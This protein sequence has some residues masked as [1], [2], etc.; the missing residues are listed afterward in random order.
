[1]LGA[2]SSWDKS[3]PHGRRAA[4][5]IRRQQL[6]SA[7]SIAAGGKVPGSS[8][9]AGRRNPTGQHLHRGRHWERARGTHGAYR[10]GPVHLPGLGS[11][12]RVRSSE[13]SHKPREPPPRK[14][15]QEA[16]RIA[17]QFMGP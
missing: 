4:A 9:P 13:G 6:C 5:S 11:T 7:H 17:G 3:S 10:S 2:W 15:T 16:V 8:A 12:N 1:M 14:T